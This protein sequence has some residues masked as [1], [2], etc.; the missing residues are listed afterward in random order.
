MLSLEGAHP[1]LSA[2]RDDRDN[3]TLWSGQ[4]SRRVGGT[5]CSGMESLGGNWPGVD[6]CPPTPGRGRE[7]GGVR[8]LGVPL[9]LL[10]VFWVLV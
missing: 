3:V 5:R 4:G 7:V 9:L 6:F 10:E 2:A 8:G 1:T